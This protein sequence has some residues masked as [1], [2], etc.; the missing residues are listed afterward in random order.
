MVGDVE[1]D[2][3]VWPCPVPVPLLRFSPQP[4]T[5]AAEAT[6]SEAAATAMRTLIRT[7]LDLIG[8]TLGS[9]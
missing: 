2:V 3:A 1:G 4:L 5:A 9:G 8:T 6:P 7:A